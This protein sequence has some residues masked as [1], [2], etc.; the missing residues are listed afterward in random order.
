MVA[1]IVLMLSPWTV[2]VKRGLGNDSYK[3]LSRVLWFIGNVKNT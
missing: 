3:N 1:A 2:S